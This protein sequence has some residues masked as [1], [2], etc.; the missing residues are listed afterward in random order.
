MTKSQINIGVS[1]E[2][3]ITVD[4]LDKIHNK[5]EAELHR[6]LLS[7]IINNQIKVEGEPCLVA[8]PVVSLFNPNV[9]N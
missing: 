9:G 2:G 4:Q 5:I 1:V 3:Q 7:L 6:F 8:T